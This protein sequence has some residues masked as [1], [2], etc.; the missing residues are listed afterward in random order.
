M[1]MN[2]A[3]RTMQNYDGAIS[4]ECRLFVCRECHTKT[5]FPHQKWCTLRESGSSGCADCVYRNIAGKSCGHPYRK[6]GGDSE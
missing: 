5:G 6:K 4:A 1:I 2:G 3:D